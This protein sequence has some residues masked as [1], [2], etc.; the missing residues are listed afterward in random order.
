MKHILLMTRGIPGLGDRF[1]CAGFA[2]SA[3]ECPAGTPLPA[4]SGVP[5]GCTA[6][7]EPGDDPGTDSAAALL[8]L[9]QAGARVII[10]SNTPPDGMRAFLF[11]RGLPDLLPLEAAS[12]A[13]EIV[14]AMDARPAAPRGSF[15]L[16]ES[17]APRAAL[18][19]AV[20]ERFGYEAVPCAGADELFSLIQNADF[21]GVLFSLG[22]P[23]LD[24]AAFIRKALA[25]GDA[26]RVPFYPYKDMHEGLFVHEIISGLNRIARVIMSPA[27][28]LS[29]LANLLFRKELFTLTDR[30]NRTIEFTGNI[31]FVRESPAR[32]YHTM[33]M[34]LFS[35]GNALS[36]EAHGPLCDIVSEVRSL[37]LKSEGLRWLGIDAVKKPT[38]GPG[39]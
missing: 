28:L 13:P 34:D 25:G 1:S 16:L 11:Q 20:I 22:T 10:M 27:E 9:Q 24:L 12:R 29:H 8:R 19:R 31:Q 39:G 6:L 14:T 38:C 35:M 3:V 21:Q 5:P 4:P 32:I 37:L 33:G 17:V 18:L 7:V 15:A 2:V 36:D 26:R 23:G 30:L